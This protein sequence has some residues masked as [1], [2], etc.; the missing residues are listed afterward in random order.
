MTTNT[1]NVLPENHRPFHLRIQQAVTLKEQMD[2]Q[3]IYADW[4]EE[5]GWDVT[6]YRNLISLQKYPLYKY[7]PIEIS[8]DEHSE[9]IEDPMG[10]LFNIQEPTLTPVVFTDPPLKGFVLG[11]SDTFMPWLAQV[12][13]ESPHIPTSELAKTGSCVRD[14]EPYI[15]LMK[16]SQNPDT[17]F[18][19]LDWLRK[20]HFLPR[21]D[22][23]KFNLSTD[24]E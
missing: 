7:I 23:P 9:Y 15:E 1:G 2:C 19:Y 11:T 5:Q 17:A 10:D 14:L 18:R 3:G 13:W 4:L 16:D 8:L 24:I 22:F 20:L 21:H 6:C 12:L